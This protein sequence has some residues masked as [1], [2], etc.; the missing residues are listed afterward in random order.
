MIES[1]LAQLVIQG[2]PTVRLV[3]KPSY[4]PV[5]FVCLFVVVVVVVVVVFAVKLHSGKV[6]NKAKSLQ[7]KAVS[8]TQSN[9]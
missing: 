2:F 3:P 6:T 5:L 4:C 1:E 8:T 7:L 9:K